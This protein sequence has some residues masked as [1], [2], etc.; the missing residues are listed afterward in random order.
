MSV[1]R[2]LRDHLRGDIDEIIIDHPPT[3]RLARN[4]LEQ[5]MPIVQ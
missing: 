2:A 4:F 5:V 1:I 3:Y